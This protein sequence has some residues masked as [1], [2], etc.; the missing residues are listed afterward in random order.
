MGDP[1]DDRKARLEEGMCSLTRQRAGLPVDR[2]DR[3]AIA[4]ARAIA[5]P[6]GGAA[7]ELAEVDW[8]AVDHLAECASCLRRDLPTRLQASGAYSLCVR[9]ETIAR[10]ELEVA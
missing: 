10:A 5:V 8:R 4:D 2:V 1:L 3:L 9:C 7:A 6:G